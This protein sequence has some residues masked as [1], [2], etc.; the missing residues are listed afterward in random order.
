MKLSQLMFLASIYFSLGGCTSARLASP[1]PPP[2]QPTGLTATLQNSPQAPS[3]PLRAGSPGGAPDVKAGA[4]F[5]VSDENGV[6]PHLAIKVSK[7]P[8]GLLGF[9]DRQVTFPMM[10]DDGYEVLIKNIP[11]N[12]EHRRYIA[13]RVARAGATDTAT[14]YLR[15]VKRWRW[16]NGFSSPVL[17]QAEGTL[18][19][20]G[21]DNFAPSLA[22]G[23]RLFLGG[24][25]NQY[26]GFNGLVT[27]F[28]V[29]ESEDVARPFSLAVGGIVDFAGIFQI[30]V[31][32]RFKDEKLRFIIGV[33]PEI[34]RF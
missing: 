2:P 33:R 12:I 6:R 32:Y 4:V 21:L 11:G 24:G 20:F 30:G 13:F 10:V 3:S 7:D 22:T 31:N 25:P 5:R 14:Y 34:W 1:A 28:R 27:V 29:A 18:A 23:P 15:Y 17:Y 26:L 9:E 8:D 19:E 16:W